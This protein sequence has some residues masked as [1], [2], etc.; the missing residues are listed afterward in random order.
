V[1]YGFRRLGRR[2]L[3]LSPRNDTFSLFI[4][5]LFLLMCHFI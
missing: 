3:I 2:W 1:S 4:K 5:T